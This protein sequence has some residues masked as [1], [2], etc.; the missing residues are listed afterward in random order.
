[1][2]VP[3]A[4]VNQY[5]TGIFRQA[6]SAA[7][8]AAY[9]AMPDAASALNSMLSA[10][11]VQVDPVVRLYQTAFN[12]VPDSAGMT[13]WVVPYSTNA[14]TLQAIANGFTQST[15]F[16]TL[17][18]TS[19][20]NAQFVGALYYNIL[21]RTGEDAGIQGWV[22]AL[23]SGAQTRAQVL[24]GFSESTE[25]KA[26][27]QS[28]VDVF[29]TGTANNTATY[30]GSLFA[31]GGSGSTTVYT[32][33][34]GV[35]V[36]VGTGANDVFDGSVNATGQ[37]TWQ[38]YDSLTGGDGNDTL[39][40]QNI[41]AVT[42][43]SGGLTG[44]E[45]LQ[46]YNQTA[47]TAVDITTATGVTTV[48]IN[49]P[50]GAATVQG[51]G[52]GIQSVAVSG[53]GTAG[54]DQQT[55]TFQNAA[56]SGSADAVTLNLTNVGATG[57]VDTVVVQPTSGVNG[58]ETINIVTSNVASNIIL[59]DGTSTSLSKITVS[60]P[61]ALTLVDA[62]TTTL[63]YDA[64]AS[65]A[66]VSMRTNTVGAV[67]MTGG[68]GND[69][70]RF[71][72]DDGTTGTY[73]TTDSVTGGT[74]TDTLVLTA[75]Q[76]TVTATQSNVTGVERIG[77]LTAA[78]LA[79][80]VDVTKFGATD[81]R[82]DLLQANAFNMVL[83]ATTATLDMQNFGANIALAITASGSGTDALNIT[84][85]TTAAANTQTGALTINGYETVNITAI[86]GAATG[87]N[88]FGAV[89]LVP[90]AGA[91]L[92]FLGS[93][94]IAVAAITASIIDASGMTGSA[95]FTQSAGAA[96]SSRI[97]GTANAD[98]LIGSATADVING[99]A[100][101][102]NISNQAAAATR[103][104]AADFLTGGAG[105]DT[106]NLYGSNASDAYSTLINTTSYITDFTYSATATS[107]DIFAVSDTVANY[108]AFAAVLAGG[109]YGG[110][111]AAGSTA[112]QS[113]AQNAAATAV[114]AATDLVKLTTGV[115][116]AGLTVQQVFNAAIGT[117][118]LTTFGANDTGVFI[119]AYD[120]TNSRMMVMLGSTGNADDVLATGDVVQLVGTVAMSAADYASLGSAQF[121]MLA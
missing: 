71:V 87:G 18:P 68:T 85:G 98:A 76:A 99:G 31:Q 91:T 10:A 12:R 13:A 42:V 97:T 100:G 114:L 75:A 50:A 82:F 9:Q 112:V 45:S 74:G 29:L 116:T 49:S 110:A 94:N 111:A 15:E 77:I 95:T 96:V 32:L 38:G 84:A 72:S 30:T 14:I 27:I 106:F 64:S 53:Q 57:A 61:V 34:P 2:P 1:M 117:A 118:T 20:S 52:A 90:S 92:N 5:Y 40:A 55:F 4:T 3:A 33:T 113:V 67:A 109:I 46:F 103:A 48:G 39:I 43:N 69:T 6:P 22:N 79:T 59:N 107:T 104:S 28:N 23:N 51:I 89:T 62:T 58:F 44:V 70:F 108:T 88:A 63:T 24:L 80:T 54:A 26:N 7:V 102:D 66:A 56:S 81:L 11:N 83:G 105:Q 121:A 86:G 101:A 35:D 73:G 93:Q 25:F 17:Y 36:R 120:T 47:A 21:Q 19:M 16:T 119:T 60:A 37:V 115:A 8:S 78:A 41:G 65:T